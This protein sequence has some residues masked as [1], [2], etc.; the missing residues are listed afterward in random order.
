MFAREEVEGECVS[1][2]GGGSVGGEGE[3]G[4]DG[5]V[6]V[7]GFR[8]DREGKGE[9]EERDSGGMTHFEGLGEAFE[10]GFEWERVGENGKLRGGK[11]GNCC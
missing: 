2:R 7:Y 1:S 10:F 3:S 4:A 11:V 9:E 6:V 5:D 8:E